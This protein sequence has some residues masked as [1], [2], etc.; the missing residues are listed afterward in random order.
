MAVAQ[1]KKNFQYR[2]E[3]DDLGYLRL[4]IEAIDTDNPAANEQLFA[5]P[6]NK[7]KMEN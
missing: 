5:H 6:A 7:Q 4:S 1:S 3:P 2:T